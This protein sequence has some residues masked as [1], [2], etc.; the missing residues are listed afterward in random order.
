M[1]EENVERIRAGF[2]AHSR[3]D[4]D[5][6][7]ELYDADAVF[8]TLLLGTHHGKEAIRRL[9]EENQTNQSGYTIEPVEMIDAGDKVVSVVQARGTG[10]ASQIALEDRF[11][12]VHTMSNGLIV[13]EQAFRN[14]EEALEAAG[15]AD[16]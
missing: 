8:E 6:M 5:A 14:R 16:H 12:F 4:I 11:A 13:R 10:P 3:G 7:V 9:Y 1:S 15:L 2:A